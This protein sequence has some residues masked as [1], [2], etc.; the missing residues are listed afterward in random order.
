MASEHGNIQRVFIGQLGDMFYLPRGGFM[1]VCDLGT[2][3]M[4]TAGVWE[5]KKWEWDRGV[6]GR[7]G[8]PGELISVARKKGG[9]GV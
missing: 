3:W 7:E 5:N 9:E 6:R 1:M 8:C 2:A 4:D